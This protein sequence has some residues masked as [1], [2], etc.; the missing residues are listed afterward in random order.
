M[1]TSLSTAP[2]EAPQ[3]MSDAAA[4]STPST[5]LLDS[6]TPAEKSSPTDG[7]IQPSPSHTGHTAL[8]S[9]VNP[10]SAPS[11]N[12]PDAVLAIPPMTDI[13][14]ATEPT[15]AA[16]NPT[17]V[18]GKPTAV[19][20]KQPTQD[21]G[22]NDVLM[23]DSS[24]LVQKPQN[25]V[26]LP[27]WLIPMIKYLHGVTMD[28]A[29]QNLV[30]EFIKFEKGDPPTRVS[31]FF[32]T[33]VETNHFIHIHRSCPQRVDP[34][35]SLTGCRARRKRLYHQSNLLNSAN[36]SWNGGLCYSLTGRKTIL[37]DHSH[38]STMF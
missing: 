12:A 19:G 21:K 34:R 5:V 37:K 24:P 30:M 11:Y 10:A 3:T 22:N 8:I 38:F 28:T 29:W 26:N 18:G 25:D 9:A 15:A 20:G 7:V 16:G 6:Q 4:C 31:F 17:A 23:S 35:R 13:R 1:L 36:S 32:F 14:L 27:P 2:L 33:K